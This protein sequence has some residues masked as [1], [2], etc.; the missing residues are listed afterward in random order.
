MRWVRHHRKYLA[1]RQSALFSVSLNAA[2]RRP[3]ARRADRAILEAFM[4]ESGWTPSHATALAGALNYRRY[5]LLVRWLMKRISRSTGGPTD[6][7]RDYEMT[8]WED[9]DGF[10]ERAL[11]LGRGKFAAGADDL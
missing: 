3:Q 4:R 5:G 1:S 11:Q 8:D 6:T 7:S 9:V 2:D 10:L